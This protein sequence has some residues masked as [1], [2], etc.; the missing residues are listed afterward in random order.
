M[1]FKLA[2]AAVLLATINFT[3][4]DNGETREFKFALE[5]DRLT[6]D[7][8]DARAKPEKGQ[9]NQAAVRKLLISITRG[10]RDQNLVLDDAT[11]QPAAFSR[12]A[13]EFMFTMPGF[14]DVALN[15]YINGVSA[16]VKN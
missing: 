14:Q 16:K 7:E 8:W 12:E 9:T 5:Q 3:T 2:V 4:N 1:A 13:L 10:W 15:A 11:G 6:E